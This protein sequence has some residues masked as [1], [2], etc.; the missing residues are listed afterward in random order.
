MPKRNIEL[1][2][3]LRTRFLRM[4]HPEH[5]NMA[6]IARKTECGAAMCLIGHTLDLA[7]YK[8]RFIECEW[9]AVGDYAWFTPNGRP[10]K[11]AF[12]TARRLL[13]LRADEVE[14]GFDRNGEYAEG[15]FYRHSLKTPRQA[16]DEIQR[17]I[18]GDK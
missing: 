2:K 17:Y 1:L 4:K 10:V 13:G 16:A 5:F 14:T 9:S 7:G 8:R 18:T 3:K 6:S 15:L 11:S 12:H